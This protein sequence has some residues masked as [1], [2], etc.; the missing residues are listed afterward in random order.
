MNKLIFSLMALCMTM[1]GCLTISGELP[2]MLDKPVVKTFSA[3]P[4]IINAGEVTTISWTVNGAN[5]VFIDQGVGSVALNGTTT[6]SPAVTTTYILTANNAAGNTTVRCQVTVKGSIQG[7]PGTP[8]GPTA[9]IPAATAGAPVV[10]SFRADPPAIAMGNRSML[11]WDVT[12]A[13]NI[14]ISPDVGPIE[15]AASVVVSPSQSTKYT[16]T[17]LNSVGQTVTSVFITVKPAEQPQMQGQNTVDLPLVLT[18]SGSLIKSGSSYAKSGAVCAG[19]TGMNLPSRAFLSFDISSIPANAVI[20]AAVLDLGAY[21][22]MGNPIYSVSGWGNMGALEVYPYQYGPTADMGRLGY[23]FAASQVGSFKLADVSG[24]PLKLDVTLDNSGNNIIGQLRAGGQSRCQFR[25]QFFTTT[26][27][28]S[29][30]DM[31]CMEA[32]MLRVKYSLPK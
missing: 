26:N 14:F 11:S 8:I 7:G 16:L 6:V 28:D 9:G 25:L 29:K 30:A 5:S 31:V 24:A 15:H 20:D 4:A 10:N 27:W 13:T 1:A 21:G 2:S 17:A 32:A 18:E 12:G 22:I 3:S 23:E 19:D